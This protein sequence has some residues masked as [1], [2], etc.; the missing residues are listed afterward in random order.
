MSAAKAFKSALFTVCGG[1]YEAP[2]L[3]SYGWPQSNPPELVVVG[4]VTSEQDIATMGVSRSREESLSCEIAFCVFQGGVINQQ[5][6]SE[7]AFDLAGMLET[8]LRDAG[9][10]ASTQITLG[11]TV[12]DARV[13]GLELIESD[14]EE[15]LRKGRAAIVNVTVEARVRL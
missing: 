3:V 10:L 1:L 15:L 6:V 12:R 13:V 7:R 14:D 4:D 2:I 8:Y 5:P 11:N 9:S